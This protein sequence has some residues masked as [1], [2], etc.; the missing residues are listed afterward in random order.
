[1]I[2]RPDAIDAA[3]VYEN[4]VV[5][6]A[7]EQSPKRLVA[8]YPAGGTYMMDCPYA[9]VGGKHQ[10][11]ETLATAR[12]FLQHLL[13]EE[14]QQIAMD[15]GFRRA[16]RKAKS[17]PLVFKPENGVRM[18]EPALLPDPAPKEVAAVTAWWRANVK[19]K[20]QVTLALDVSRSMD[21]QRIESLKRAAKGLVQDL[22]DAERIAV[23]TFT[24]DVTLMQEM[25]DVGK[26]REKLVSAIDAIKTAG[27]TYLVEATRTA[28]E[29][30][31]KRV[32][33]ARTSIV[34]V[35]TDG[36]DPR[37]RLHEP[38]FLEQEKAIR[39][40]KDVVVFTIGIGDEGEVDDAML[41]R[42][43]SAPTG[44][45]RGTGQDIE[46]IFAEQVRSQF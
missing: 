28:V 27:G 38:A 37:Y 24:R 31:Q 42:L 39:A 44:F 21:G 7:K 20:A 23:F 30:A 33:A 15:R 8:V 34:V 41:K 46:G 4:L 14:Q 40:A 2:A 5:E 22:A 16:D 12:L 10:S 6:A 13:T 3:F 45:T 35:M 18:E 1:M 29:Y 19:K 26:C 43:A 17:S 36:K 25:E 9:I 11:E 32:D